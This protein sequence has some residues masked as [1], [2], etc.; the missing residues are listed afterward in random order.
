M[1]EQK[2][3]VKITSL[4]PRVLVYS[5]PTITKTDKDYPS[6]PVISDLSDL[7]E[8]LPDDSFKKKLKIFIKIYKLNGQIGQIGQ[9]AKKKS[10]LQMSSW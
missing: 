6:S 5:S 4:R 1:L 10:L 7:S 8:Q 2:Q 3:G 9:I